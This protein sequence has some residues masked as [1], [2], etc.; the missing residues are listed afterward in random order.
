MQDEHERSEQ[1]SRNLKSMRLLG[2]TGAIAL[3]V[4]LL[5]PVILKQ[6]PPF[7]L[8]LALG[9]AFLWLTTWVWEGRP[10]KGWSAKNPAR[11]DQTH[12]QV[13]RVTKRHLIVGLVLGFG[14]LILVVIQLSMQ[15]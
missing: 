7:L 5:A 10:P 2:G 1:W 14:G 9:P 13:R 8:L 3:F 15:H 6:L 4:G 12:R 11:L